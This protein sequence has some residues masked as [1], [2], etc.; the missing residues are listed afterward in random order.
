MEAICK[1]NTCYFMYW[2]AQGNWLWT[3]GEHREFNLNLN[4]ATLFYM[5]V[6]QLYKDKLPDNYSI[7]N[8]LHPN[9]QFQV[10]RKWPE[11]Q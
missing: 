3:Q 11:A 8:E 1:N 7:F 6:S 2:K 10:A 5:C 9:C 4:V